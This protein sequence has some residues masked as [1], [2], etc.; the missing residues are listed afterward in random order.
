[1]TS[2]SAGIIGTGMMGRVHAD[3]I[4]R[5]GAILVAVAGSSI[6]RATDS[7]AD[8]RFK[9]PVVSVEALLADR[10]IDVVH[11][12]VPNHLH[13]EYSVAAIEAGKHVVCEK[14]LALTPEQ[15]ADLTARAARAG[16]V[17]TIPFVYR[18]HPLV[19]EAHSRVG[20]GDA[21]RIHL[22][23]GSYLQDWLSSSDDENWRVEAQRGGDS[24]AFSDIG[25]HWCDVVE[26]VSGLRITEVS[27]STSTVFNTRGSVS[28]ATEDIASVNLRFD[29]GALGALVVSQV[30][31]G[32]KN[33]LY[34]EL[35]GAVASVAFD[36]EQ[37]ETMWWATTATTT[38]VIRDPRF[39]S[40]EA[41]A[42]SALP[43][44][45][46]M[47][48]S[49]C[50]AN[51]VADTYRAIAGSTRDVLPTFSDGLRTAR[52]SVAV[53]ESAR[54]NSWVTVTP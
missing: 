50:F 6:D 53:M 20:S 36:Q 29:N 49:D 1:M 35:S 27:A 13:Y 18:Y 16:V 34:F 52:I 7:S 9:V 22:V 4:R 48:Y 26:W 43:A 21:G 37:P 10:S 31:P 2:I 3:A 19:V 33:R 28:V 32:R 54:S 11:I 23:H 8:W 17:A 47:G 15:A 24:R 39:L 12:C 41:A 44:G 30:S 45:H 5:S 14:P 51:F 40:A 25:S 38:T 42:L 46:P